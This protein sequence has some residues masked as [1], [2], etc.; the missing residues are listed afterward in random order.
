MTFSSNPLRLTMR[1]ARQRTWLLVTASFIWT[2]VHAVPVLAGL[3]MRGFFDALAPGAAAATS[4]WTFLVLALSVDVVRMAGLGFGVYT[5]SSY[6]LEITLHLRRNVLRHLLT[7]SGARRLPASPS[8]AVTRFRDDVNDIG[9]YVENWVDF[10]GIA[11]YGVLALVILMVVNPLMTGLVCLPLVLT[12][13]LTSVLRPTIRSA[14]RASRAATSRVTDFLGETFGSVQAVKASGREDAVLR[15]YQTL[16]RT[17]RGAALKDTLLTEL[18]R[19]VND[20]M[21][22]V[23]TGVILL[24]AAGALRAGSFTVGDFA[25]FV[26]YLP[27]LTNSFSFMGLMVVQHKRTGIAY[28]RLGRLMVDA[29]VEALVRTE[30]LA[31]ERDPQPF[32]ENRETSEPFDELRVRGLSYRH[33]DADKGIQEVDLTVR[34]GEFVVVTGRLGAGKTTLLRVLLGLLPRDAG[35]IRWNG[36]LVDDPATF[37]VPPRVA[38]ASQVP[39]LFSDSVRENVLMGRPLSERAVGSALDMAVLTPD[40]AMLDEGLETEVGTRGVKLSGGQVQRAAAARLFLREAEVMVFDDVSSALDVQT[41]RKLW[42][43]LFA[44]REA[45][46]LVVSHRRAAL[47]RADRV[48][49]MEGGRVAAEGTLAEVLDRSPELRQ[50]WSRGGVAQG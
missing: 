30:S 33:P 6:W 47:E 37:L 48:V 21:I 29:P 35:E 45:T 46:C 4:P 43:G 44:A 24:V 49:L 19:S 16:N 40:I 18:F 39:R 31:L 2:V 25:L 32:V 14:R 50:V 34:R 36:E 13:A 1:L 12:L 41:E 7:A 3:F 38:Y 23:A 15:R 42:D 20:N 8:E 10:W 28:E 17:R 9:E 22:N 27:R 26:S 11:V 5:W